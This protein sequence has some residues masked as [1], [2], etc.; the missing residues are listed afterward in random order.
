MESAPTIP[1]DSTRL[2]LIAMMTVA[3]IMVMPISETLKLLEYRTPLN[4][5]LYNK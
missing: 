1:S 3:V 5:R 2:E 4:T